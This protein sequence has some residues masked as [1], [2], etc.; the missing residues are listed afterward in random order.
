M[1]NRK[2]ILSIDDSKAV[3]AYLDT[4]FPKEDYELVHAMNALEGISLL[5][6]DPSFCSLIL[7][8]WEMPEMTGPEALVAIRKM[9]VSKP[10]IMVTTKNNPIEIADMLSKGANEYIMKP[11]TPDII[12]EKVEMVLLEAGI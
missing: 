1:S 11:F 9:G 8:D 7:L 2:V 5:K 3:H 10:I 12:I 6:K 4:C